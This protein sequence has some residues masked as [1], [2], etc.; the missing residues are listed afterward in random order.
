M[1][2]R[3][4]LVLTALTLLL[5]LTGGLAGLP[6][7]SEPMGRGYFIYRATDRI[8]VDGAPDDT[9]WSVADWSEP[10]VCSS[11]S[12]AEGF[13]ARLKALWLPNA[14]D[15]ALIDLYLLVEVVGDTTVST[16]SD[17]RGDSVFLTVQDSADH[18]FWTGAQVIRSI[19]RENQSNDRGRYSF[20]IVD[21]RGE[22]ENRYTVEFC[23]PIPKTDETLFDIWVQ[24]NSAADLTSDKPRAR[25]S[26]NGITT[27]SSDDPPKGRG[28][29]REK[30]Q[31]ID[32]TA[33]VLLVDGGQ[34][35][36]SL[37]RDAEGRVVLPDCKVFGT[38]IG[39]RDS[40]GGLYPVG[41]S[42]QTAGTGQTTLEAVVLVSTLLELLDG[43]GILIEE[44]T[45]IRFEARGDLPGLTA[46]LGDALLEKGAVTVEGDRLTEAI[47][48]DGGFD[49]TELDAAGIPYQ[50][51]VFSDPD[52]DGLWR[53]VTEN[54]TDRA[55]EY[56]VCLYVRIR[57]ADGGERSLA[58][59]G[60]DAAKHS[61]SIRSVAAAACED[62]SNV[63]AKIGGIDYRFK[64][65]SYSYSPYTKEQLTFLETL[66]K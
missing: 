36:A 64:V 55:V 59:A 60:F 19:V 63:I 1:K 48:S 31:E 39:W 18:Q 13:R 51:T 32:P 52:A 9:A 37:W 41:A 62:R 65:G 66:G 28:I 26:W 42:Y 40:T 24:D 16:L 6:A 50:K 3:I 7:F 58:V 54:V 10:F 20:G 43:A 12:A 57:Y 45:A 33:D 29:I 21:R 27:G 17:W 34:P 38:L 46:L 61:R 11:G 15:E 22:A 30:K 53:T 4:C 44:P 56:A 35:V 23:H 5:A 8:T 2:K 14:E 49:P 25:Y 47:L